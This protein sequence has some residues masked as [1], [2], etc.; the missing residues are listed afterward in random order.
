MENVVGVAFD[1]VALGA[2][3]APKVNPDDFVSVFADVSL[4]CG[5]DGTPKV[6]PVDFVSVLPATSLPEAV[7]KE[8]LGAGP[9]ADGAAA[10]L[11]L[12]EEAGAAPDAEKLNTLAPDPEGFFDIALD[13]AAAVV[14]KPGRGAS[15][16]AH[17]IASGLLV[18]IHMSHFQL[19]SIEANMFVPHDIAPAPPEPLSAPAF[20][21][22]AVSSSVSSSDSSELKMN[23]MYH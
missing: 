2:D 3:G 11:K 4:E 12:P 9:D 14:S 10:K 22:Y 18:T 5:A 16:A 17:L 7:P 6:K 20:G 13:S 21:T 19:P 8:N 1:G 23:T 15:H